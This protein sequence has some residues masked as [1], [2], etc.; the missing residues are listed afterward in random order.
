MRERGA[1][2][3]AASRATVL[4]LVDETVWLPRS[5]KLL[6][7]VSEAYVER[8]LRSFAGRV[9]VVPF[10]SVDELLRALDDVAPDVVFN[11]TQGAHGDRRMD[12]HVCAV[13]ELRGVAYTGTG[14]RGLML[15]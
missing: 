10:I 7:S 2:R 11:M 8:A 14:P 6:D 12:A 15:C 1:V 4:L 5:G 9:V 3:E 13:L